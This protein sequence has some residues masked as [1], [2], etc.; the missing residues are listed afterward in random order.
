[1]KGAAILLVNMV[2]SEVTSVSISKYLLFFSFEIANGVSFSGSH[3]GVPVT[4]KLNSLFILRTR[5]S[6]SSS[7]CGVTP[8]SIGS[9]PRINP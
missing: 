1:M 9:F 4:L 3:K 7:E 8:S 6:N 2:A 5:V